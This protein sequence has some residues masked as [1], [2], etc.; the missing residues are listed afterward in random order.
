V[1]D[2]DP[3]YF[4]S[5]AFSHDGSTLVTSSVSSVLG[6]KRGRLRLWDVSNLLNPVRLAVIEE[7]QSL[8]SVAFSPNGPTLVTSSVGGAGGRLR[9]WDVSNLRTPVL[10]ASINDDRRLTTAAFLPNGPTLA[11]LGQSIDGGW[12]LVLRLVPRSIGPSVDL[13]RQVSE[14]A[15]V[16]AGGGFSEEEWQKAVPGIPY[17]KSCH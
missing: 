3:G 15:C 7:G 17:E 5:A 13:H 16:A 6:S 9:L 8:T 1:V 2:D 14:W 12:R 11:T 4:T 10:V